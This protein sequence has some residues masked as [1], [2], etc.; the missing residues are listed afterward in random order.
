MLLLTRR[1]QVG[2]MPIISLIRPILRSPLMGLI[3][4]SD[5]LKYMKYAGDQMASRIAAET[6][7]PETTQKDFCHYLFNAKDSETGKGFS[8]A[9]LNADSGLI[10]SAGSDTTALS[11]AATFFYLLHNPDTLAKL[12]SEV[13]SS[14]TS[15]DEINSKTLA[16]LPYLRACID[17]AL[18]LSPPAAGHLPREVLPGGLTIDEHYFPA[19][20]VVGT[21]AYAIHHSKEYY[22]D[23]FTY[24]PERWIIDPTTTDD[25]DLRSPESV[26]KARAAFCAF[27]HGPRGC[28][29]KRVAYIEM[30]NAV[31]SLL[32][33]HDMR[34][35]PGAE[36][37]GGGDPGDKHWGRRRVDEF[38]LRDNFLAYRDGPKVEFKLRE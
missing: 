28:I 22:P 30:S 9:E 18:R 25:N 8:T 13:R 32:F 35:A 11:L 2:Y 21:S 6:E 5:S 29:G 20:T 1:Y 24:C 38:Q 12:T 3:A 37:F 23:P 15:P 4:D 10:I 17:E 26:A 34:L 16:K 33:S 31:A 7:H 36:E 14:F 19:G 27:S